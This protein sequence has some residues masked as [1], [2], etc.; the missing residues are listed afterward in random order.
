MIDRRTRIAA[1]SAA[2]VSGTRLDATRVDRLGMQ[3][4]TVRAHMEKDFEG[5]L[6][7]VAGK[8]SNTRI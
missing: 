3:L 6:A 8:G 4:Y 7:K 1:M 2:A 5:T